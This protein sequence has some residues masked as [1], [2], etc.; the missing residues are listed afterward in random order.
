MAS[1]SG[2]GRQLA[3]DVDFDLFAGK[4]GGDQARE[5]FF[6]SALDGNETTVDFSR[7]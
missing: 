2:E 5:I 1:S 3:T 4:L 6:A 7:H